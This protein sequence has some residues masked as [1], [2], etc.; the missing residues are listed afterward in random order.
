METVGMAEV[1]AWFEV[2]GEP[3]WLAKRRAELKDI[4]GMKR[5]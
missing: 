4:K 1:D 5:A 2:N 3:L